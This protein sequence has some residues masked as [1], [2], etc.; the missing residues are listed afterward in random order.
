MFKNHLKIAWRSL[1]KQP[2]FTFLNTFGL[3]IGIAGGILISL[4]IYDELSYDK[5]FADA[6][7]IHRIHADIK[8]G[9]EDRKFAVTPAP[10]AESAQNDFS[11]VELAMRFRTQG[12]M[13]VRKSDTEANIK[14]IQT[15]YVDSTFFKMFGLDLLVGD[16]KTALKSPNTLIL[17]KSAAEKHFSVNEAVGQTL[18]LD[19]DN[20]YTVTGVIEDF[21]K[22]SFLRDH[23]VFIAM[24]GYE[25]SRI[26][27]WGSNNYQTYIKL[28][29]NANINDIQEPLRGFLDKYVIP[30]V[31]QFMPGITKEQFEAA[32]NHLI[33]ST[34]PMT[35]IHLHSDRVAEISGNNDIQSIYIL[36]FIAI[37]LLVLACVNFMN[38]STAHSLKRAKEVGIR[39]T[40]GSKRG[41]L[42]RQF[43]IE[44]GLV[45]L[46]SLLLA[47]VLA[48]ILLPLFNDLADKDI[49]MPY[50]N[51][52]FWLLLLAAGIALGL[53]SGG[54]PAFFMSKFIPVKVLK[55]TSSNSIGGGKVRNALVIFQFAISVF[56]IVGTLVVYQQLDYIQNKDLGFSKDQ[57]LIV[58][59]AFTLGNK[60]TSFKEEVK[61]LSYVKD[62]TLSSFF[63]TPSSRS[64]STF[65]PE[66]G[67]TDQENALNMQRWGVDHD[68]VS[69][70][71][72]EIIAGR[73][74]NH[75]FKND[76]TAIIV[77]ESAVSVI[78]GSP[79]DAIGKRYT[80]DFSAENPEYF[81]II[82]VVKDF[83]FSPF[84]ADIESLS[85]HLSNRAYALAIKLESGEFTNAIS[86]I[87]GIWNQIAPGQPFDYYF[88]EDSFNDT[89]Q[90][91]QRLGRI[92]FIF[93]A[94]SILIA[95]LG[96]F[97]L[98]AFNAE[99]RTKEIGIRKVLGASVG[100]ISYKL[101][102]DFLKLVG[103]A[104]L[105]SLPLGWFAMN[106]WLEDFSYRI[107]IGI[108]VFVFAALLAI[109]I[110]IITVSYQSIKAAI[111]NPIKS[112]RTE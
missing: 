97:G 84:R 94:L 6:D 80:P 87:E 40:L 37:F 58:N 52:F 104:I 68:Y 9:G 41:E 66:E 2:F 51:P 96:L 22:N 82:G 101:S 77:N 28:I 63:P 102:V 20:S 45:S 14:E 100:Q 69:T 76:S 49:S 111:V 24:S 44:S 90:S 15:T 72:F 31:Q 86:G 57:V 21:P 108:W 70:M 55:G 64:D 109:A 12:S 18:I 67:L 17:T 47:V 61:K 78:G 38:L 92:F 73:D 23:T 112:L 16:I 48:I 60:S 34:M 56:L 85:L 91:E 93:T 25:D 5:M 10:M 39:K 65:A 53:F 62:A 95:C 42:I 1:K 33:Y 74:F 107:E 89:Y 99:K 106:K 98:A 50:T 13:L 36:S 54:Y 3:A 27:N 75:D 30:G 46:A 35:D 110:S 71:N 81:T 32:G 11:E 88:M 19:N 7:R 103:V 59:D 4:Y 26:V 79:E 29:P 43:L 83:H 8:F 105:V